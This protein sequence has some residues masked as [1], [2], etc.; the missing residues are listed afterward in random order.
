[1]QDFSGN[2]CWSDLLSEI[3]VNESNRSVFNEIWK[4]HESRI[5][6]DFDVDDMLPELKATGFCQGLPASYSLLRDGL[7]ARFK[8]N[9]YISSMVSGSDPAKIGIISNMY[10]R[11][12]DAIYEAGIMPKGVEYAHVIDSSVVGMQKPQSEI[13]EYAAKLA[14]C[15]P[16]E[17]LFADNSEEHINAAKKQGWN[18]FLY[19]SS[20][21]EESSTE[22]KILLDGYGLLL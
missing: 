18:T 3:G 20:N 16:N 10:P 19:E 4:S 15:K 21:A 2:S 9:A 6:L 1:M 5:C 7:V 22:L 8:A 13:F 17:L 11:M 12:L 14:C